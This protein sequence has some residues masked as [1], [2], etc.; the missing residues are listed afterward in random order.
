MQEKDYLTTTQVRKY[1][2][3]AAFVSQTTFMMLAAYQRDRVLIIV[4]ITFG[5][6][7]GAL[8]ICG[9]GVNHLDVAPQYASILM[10]LSNTIATIPGIVSP[11][12]A[13][14]IVTEQTVRKRMI[15]YGTHQKLIFLIIERRPMAVDFHTHFLRVFVRLP[16][17]L[18]F[19]FGR[20]ST[21][22]QNQR[23]KESRIGSN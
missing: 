20:D 19:C 3:C 2:N 16:R 1:F 8:S 15:D 11:L 9:Y 7:L 12:I 22:G 14:F 10:G 23:R 5:A 21:V 13:G 17:V 4:F 6:S 18:D